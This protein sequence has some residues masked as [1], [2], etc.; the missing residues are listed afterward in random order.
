MPGKRPPGNAA[1]PYY[2]PAPRHAIL[3]AR[4]RG[5]GTAVVAVMVV[6]IIAVAAAAVYYSGTQRTTT[7]V[8]APPVT[9]TQTTTET[10]TVTTTQIPSTSSASSSVCSSTTTISST[11]AQSSLVGPGLVDLA[12]NFTSLSVAYGQ[13][14]SGASVILEQTYNLV[15]A[16]HTT[17]KMTLSLSASPDSGLTAWVLTNGTVLAA[18]SDGQNSSGVHASSLIVT[19]YPIF[20]QIPAFSPASHFSIPLG[21]IHATGSS[22]VTLGSTRLTV[23]DYR[24]DSLPLV[25][26]DDAAA[27]SLT[28]F[29]VQTAPVPGTNFTL[30]TYIDV[31]GTEASAPLSF[32]FLVSSVTLA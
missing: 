28:T 23:T 32:Y 10:T 19:S 16:S 26:C 9:T 25:Y 12:R 18:E 31:Q 27:F 2:S 14:S 5:V 22:N 4:K 17:Y 15:Y 7:T 1:T 11:A 30:F 21:E 6:V 3:V 8:T 20:Y 24:A 29:V 13:N